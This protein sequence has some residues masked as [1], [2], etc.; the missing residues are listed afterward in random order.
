MSRAYRIKV[1]ETTTQTVRGKD[2]ICTTLEILDILSPEET[3]ELLKGVL[4]EKGFQQKDDGVFTRVKDGV[5]VDINPC[6]GE[7]VVDVEK[8]EQ[9]T[10]TA[11]RDGIGFND[12]GAKPEDLKR[13]LKEKAKEDTT[14]IIGKKQEKLQEQASRELEKALAEI[15]PELAGIVNKVTREAL[16]RKAGRMGTVTRADENEQTGELTLEVELKN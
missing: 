7:V 12:V 8:E 4:T 13:K 5:T 11:T 15:Q 3:A 6:D 16:K 10:A 9:V 2:T 14:A 1:K